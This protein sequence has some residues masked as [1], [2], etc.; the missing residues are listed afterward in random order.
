MPSEVIT[1]EWRDI[2]S[3]NAVFLVNDKTKICIDINWINFCHNDD[4]N[5]C[6]SLIFVDVTQTTANILFT[7]DDDN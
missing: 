5:D 1:Q 6:N 7:S 4:A 3:L 2:D